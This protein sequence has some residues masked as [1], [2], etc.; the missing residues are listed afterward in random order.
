MFTTIFTAI[1]GSVGGIVAPVAKAFMDYKTAALQKDVEEMR[2]K[3]EVAMLKAQMECQTQLTQM[4]MQEQ[5]QAAQQAQSMAQIQADATVEQAVQQTRVEAYKTLYS[6][7]KWI[8]GFISLIRPFL[9]LGLVGYFGYVL[10]RLM[11]VVNLGKIDLLDMD[12]LMGFCKLPPIIALIELV[13]L[14][15]SFWFG[16]RSATKAFS[17][18]K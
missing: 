11:Q 10:L 12:S 13:V 6:G 1:L 8:D 16:G 15:V 17:G 18:G 7:V 5:L 14:V 3:N 2:G 9:T 4:Q